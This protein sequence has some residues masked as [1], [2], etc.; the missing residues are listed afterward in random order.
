MNQWRLTQN[1]TKRHPSVRAKYER[2]AHLY[3]WLDR[4]FERRRYRPLRRGMFHGLTGLVLDAG[5]GTGCNM[6]FYPSEARVIGI[7]LS[8]AMLFQAKG[9]AIRFGIAARLAQ[10][11]IRRTG[12]AQPRE[13]ELDAPENPFAGIG[14]RAVE[15]EENVHGP[16]RGSVT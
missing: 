15:I 8:R 7:D 4:P 12:F 16:G 13:G 14:Q 2:I 9:K 6:P 11:D 3:D 1:M 5:V 10:M